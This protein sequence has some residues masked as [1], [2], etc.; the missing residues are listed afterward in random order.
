MLSYEILMSK[1]IINYKNI[2]IEFGYPIRILL[3]LY[4]IFTNLNKF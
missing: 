1:I 3:I 2:K 4:N